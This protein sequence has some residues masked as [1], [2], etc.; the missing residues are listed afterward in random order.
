VG[1]LFS[2][3]GKGRVARRKRPILNHV[4]KRYLAVQPRKISC[5]TGKKKSVQ[6]RFQHQREEKSADVATKV[7]LSPKK[8][9]GTVVCKT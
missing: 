7:I 9:G 1:G 3:S 8:E 5:S 4:K 2:H 6:S